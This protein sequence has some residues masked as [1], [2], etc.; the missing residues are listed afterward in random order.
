MALNK[1]ALIANIELDVADNT[2][3]DISAQDVRD[4][5]LDMVDTIFDI[6]GDGTRGYSQTITQ[7]SSTSGALSVIGDVAVT[8]NL[9]I[10]GIS[11][12][13]SVISGISPVTTYGVVFVN[14][15]GDGVESDSRLTFDYGG[16]GTFALTSLNSGPTGSDFTIHH[17]SASPT[18]GDVVGSISFK[19]E[20]SASNMTTY[21]QIR[22]LIQD[23]NN[24]SEDGALVFSTIKA[25]TLTEAFRVDE[26]GY[27]GI[28]T[29]SPVSKLHVT[30]SSG[31][32]IATIIQAGSTPSVN[33][34]DIRNSVGTSQLAVD[35]SFGLVPTTNNTLT[36]GTS[37]N[38]FSSINCRETYAFGSD[39][40]R[41]VKIHCSS[42]THPTMDFFVGGSRKL[43]FGYDVNLS[44]TALFSDTLGQGYF[45]YDASGLAIGNDS[46]TYGGNQVL[47]NGASTANT[48]I[49]RTSQ[50]A[51][52]VLTVRGAAAQ[53]GNLL[54][55]QN[56]S[57]TQLSAFNSSGYFI[58]G[59]GAPQYHLDIFP[60][61]NVSGICLRSAGTYT[62]LIDF[63]YS[64]ASRIGR[65]YGSGSNGAIDSSDIQNHMYI[66]SVSTD[67]HIGR[68][69]FTP[70]LRAGTTVAI[71]GVAPVSTTSLVVNQSTVNNKVL[72]IRTTQAAGD[73]VAEDTIQQKITTT[74]ATVTYTTIQTAAAN[75]TYLIQT[76]VIARRTAGGAAGDSNG[77]ILSGLFKDVAGTVTQIGTTGKTIVGESDPACDADYNVSGTSIRLS[78]TGI[79]AVDYT[80]HATS[81]ISILST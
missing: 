55:L 3:G 24:G 5:V 4:N 46:G 73:P 65:F 26:N 51:A 36:V 32:E 10:N 61:T 68:V 48:V 81:K 27:F 30:A 74:N 41:Y 57:S 77:Y 72:T 8:G 47:I 34:L 70:P 39:T 63:Y 18:G 43:V 14:G 60:Q 76:T 75:Y 50:A 79:A 38:Q 40:N 33:I 20:D 80:W 45:F 22:G 29:A 9:T 25:G 62:A 17:N 54:E 7:G 11:P 69:G 21:A 56:S 44:R 42:A 66:K 15:A 1:T 6:P 2:T 67:V 37:A 28:G 78:V 31:S 53:T 13:T 59:P 64:T 58:I 12:I 52:K 49:I 23:A 19:G 16:E 35:S 71:G